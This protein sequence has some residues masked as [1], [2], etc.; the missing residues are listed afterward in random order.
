M[1]KL[2]TQQLSDGSQLPVTALLE[3][4]LLSRATYYRHL[5]SPLSADQDME[6]R[7]HIQRLALEWPQ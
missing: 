7:D 2:A 6:L 4:L 3:T 1:L 5:A